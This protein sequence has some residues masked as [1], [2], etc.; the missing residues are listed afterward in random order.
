MP[1]E[2]EGGPPEE[3]GP[4]PPREP[5]G[6]TQADAALGARI[7]EEDRKLAA[8]EKRIKTNRILIAVSFGLTL[9]AIAALATSLVAVNRDI[10]AVAKAEPKEASVGTSAIQDGAVTPPKLATGAVTPAKL[11]PGAVTAEKLAEASVTSVAIASQAVVN[12]GL[13]PKAVGTKKLADA[14]VTGAKTAKNTLTGANIDES[15]LGKV[16]QAANA[17][18]AKSANNASSLGGV[19][20]AAYVSGL[21][22]A[23]AVS[24]QNAQGLKGPIEASCPSGTQVVAG[25]AAI[26]GDVQGVAITTSAPSGDAAWTAT[27]EAF[28]PPGGAWQLV[29]TAI[30]ASGGG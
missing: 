24:E 10:E 14:A 9:L 5:P 16:P 20:A 27:A 7:A 23:Q 11:A 12:A 29:V 17:D 1:D 2:Q 6:W 19:Q 22:L 18:K 26:S 28:E 13:A 4:A 15:T 8:E 21:Q 3:R 30:C 25:G